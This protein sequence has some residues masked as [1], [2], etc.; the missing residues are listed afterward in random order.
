MI[1]I[2]KEVFAK[3][4]DINDGFLRSVQF[5]PG[6]ASYSV[7]RSVDDNGRMAEVTLEMTIPRYSRL[8]RDNLMVVVLLDDGTRRRLGTKDLPVRFEFKE[9]AVIRATC[10]WQVPE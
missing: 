2:V 6:T 5:V 8:L 7:K 3:S 1:K 9:D 4:L 10:K